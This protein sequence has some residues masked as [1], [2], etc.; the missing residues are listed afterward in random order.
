MTTL[1]E[2]GKKAKK[3]SRVLGALTTEQKNKALNLIADE[4]EVQAGTVLEQ[5]KLDINDGK[6]VGL[7]EAVLD[8][9][10]LT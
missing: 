1:L 4:L 2:M 8:R 10:L 5:N 6:A 3:A 9:L 7:S